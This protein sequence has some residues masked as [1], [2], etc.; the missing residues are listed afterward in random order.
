MRGL[1]DRRKHYMTRR[2]QGAFS[3]MSEPS[4]TRRPRRGRPIIEGAQA[5][6]PG[7][8]SVLSARISV[9]VRAALEAE[10]DRTGRS[11][12]QVAERWLDDARKG[13]AEYRAMLGGTQLASTIEKLVDI[14]KDVD[15]LVAP[16][17][18]NVALHVA[19]L[20]ALPYIIPH[21]AVSDDDFARATQYSRLVAACETARLAIQAAPETDPVRARLM[22]PADLET[23]GPSLLAHM[24][25]AEEQVEPDL[26]P[27]LR[28]LLHSGD[29]AGEEIRAAMGEQA[30]FDQMNDARDQRKRDAARVGREVAIAH[31]RRRVSDQVASPQPEAMTR[32]ID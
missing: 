14:A 11:I 5:D 19:W 16:E 29:T 3:V 25:D 24:L 28:K 1:R 31:R 23:D 30:A 22:A 20:A 26:S 18:R 2:T 10:A 9:E 27:Y 8:G 7:L 6:K 21:D 4:K 15:R 17:F 13:Q 12:S 32:P